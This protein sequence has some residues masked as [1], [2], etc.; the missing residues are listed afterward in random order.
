MA[1]SPSNHLWDTL[2]PLFNITPNDTAAKVEE[3]QNYVRWPALF[4][5]RLSSRAS[6]IRKSAF[7]RWKA[8][9]NACYALR[10]G[11]QRNVIKCLTPNAFATNYCF[12]FN[13]KIN[14]PVHIFTVACLWMRLFPP[15]STEVSKEVPLLVWRCRPRQL[16]VFLTVVLKAKNR[17]AFDALII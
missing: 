16:P 12:I 11:D 4:C 7:Q 17:R 9:G 10:L 15:V 14:K 6:K 8:Y 3:Y 5:S 1:Y 13:K 2:F